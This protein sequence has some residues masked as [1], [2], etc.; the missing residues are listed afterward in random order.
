M[1][2]P[3]LVCVGLSLLAVACG[4]DPVSY[5]QPVGINLKAKSGDVG[6][7]SVVQDDKDINT[8]SGNP[9]GAFIQ[10]ARNALGGVN[11]GRIE[12]ASVTLLLGGTSTNVTALEQVYTGEVDLLFVMN[13]SNNTYPVARIMNPTGQGPASMTVI[14]ASSSVSSVDMPQLLGGGFKL[15]IR[16]TAAAGFAT[17]SA[18]ADL[19]VTLTFQA[20]QS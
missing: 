13:T 16:G 14:W 17:R 11:P 15:V 12:V 20:F 9:Y 6:A 7:G 3:A 19:Q 8:E 10:N 2:I 1:K 4:S 18:E 5:S